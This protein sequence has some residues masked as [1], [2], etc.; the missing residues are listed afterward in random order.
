VV[1]GV[2]ATVALGRRDPLEGMWGQDA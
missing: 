1:A 2:L